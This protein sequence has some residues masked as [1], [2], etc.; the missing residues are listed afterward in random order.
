[1]K[2]SL[3]T[4][5]VFMLLALLLPLLIAG[6]LLAGD[7]DGKPQAGGGTAP[8]PQLAPEVSI[9]PRV[10]T[11]PAAPENDARPALGHSRRQ[12]VVLVPVAVTTRRQLRNRP[13]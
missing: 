6:V 13:G 9:T 11:G 1:M 7:Q 10:R 8:I 5:S 2:R 4:L 3:I 12:A